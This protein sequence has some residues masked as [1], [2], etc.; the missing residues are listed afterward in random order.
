MKTKTTTETQGVHCD[1]DYAGLYLEYKKY[2][3]D[4]LTILLKSVQ[5][6][7]DIIHDLFLTL[8]E[9]KNLTIPEN[10]RYYLLRAAV[11]RAT[12]YI[13]K[14]RAEDKTLSELNNEITL[15]S[16]F[17]SEIENS[18]IEGEVIDTLF[19]LVSRLGEREKEI[20][21]EKLIFNRNNV[22]IMK[23]KNI[24]Y[25]SIKKIEKKFADIVREKLQDYFT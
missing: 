14:N 4:H 5:T 8:V 21:I 16:N 1:S 11:N 12:D 13:R 15:N 22:Y 18:Y 20:L 24:T 19:D 2:L 3:E 25:Y 9:N 23:K 6:A 7:E 10:P 17:Y